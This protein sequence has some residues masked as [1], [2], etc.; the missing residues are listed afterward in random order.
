MIN[1]KFKIHHNDIGPN[2]RFSINGTCVATHENITGDLTID[3]PL[4]DLQETNYLFVE[5]YGKDP[6]RLSNQPTD[7]PLSDIAAEILEIRFDNILLDR[8]HMYSQFFFPNWQYGP[9][10]AF[11]QMNCYLGY[12]G[13]WQLIFPKNYRDWILDM[14]NKKM[15]VSQVAIDESA[16]FDLEKF[17]QDF[18]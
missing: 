8:E 14:H 17:K 16:E 15:F 3:L 18:F 11:L 7:Q 4:N 13:T 6:S 1:V 9:A 10:P 12:N 5:H 2:L